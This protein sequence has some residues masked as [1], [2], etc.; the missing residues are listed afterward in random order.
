MIGS[1]ANSGS[2]ATTFRN[3]VIACSDSSRSASMLT[4]SR[5]A[6]PRPARGRPRSRPVTSSSSISRRKRAE[7]VTFV[8]SPI[9]TKPVSG[10]ISNGSSR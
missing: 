4:S 2:A 7:P 1:R 8:R 6:P 9:I 10:P 5:L 3:V